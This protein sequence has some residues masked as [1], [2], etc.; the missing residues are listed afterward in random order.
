MNRYQF[1]H[2]VINKVNDALEYYHCDQ[3]NGN[4][5]RGNLTM[6]VLQQAYNQMIK[7]I[8]ADIE[9]ELYTN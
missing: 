5:K 9:N 8:Q 1:A 3:C 4:H 2:R 6:C 7:N